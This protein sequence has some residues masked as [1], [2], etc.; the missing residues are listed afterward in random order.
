MNNINIYF[1][2]EGSTLREALS[3]IEDGKIK[4]ALVVNKNNSLIGTM[5]DGDV[6]RAI[7]SNVDLDQT[8]NN[9]YCTNP[10][11]ASINDTKKY[12]IDLCIVNQIHQIPVLDNN[13]RIVRL[14]V[15]DELLSKKK[16]DNKVILMV[17][18]LGERLRPFTD[19]TPKPMLSVG[20]RPILQTIVGQILSC[21]FSNIIMC[22]GYR[23]SI[24]Q[25]FFGDGSKFGVKIEYI[26][27][28]ERMGTIG[29]LSL[30]TDQQKPDK[31][32]IVMNGDLLTKARFD[33]LI[34]FHVTNEAEA[35]ISVKEH[36]FKVPY[37]VLNLKDGRVLSLEEKPVKNYFVSAGIYVLNPLLI[38]HINEKKYLDI[39][40]FFD[41]LIALN[42]TIM[43]FPISEYWLDIGGKAEF[44]KANNE[45]HKVFN[46]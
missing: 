27:E 18:G 9:H 2:K 45:Y 42:K 16:Y 23:S 46:V 25:D 36:N 17:G 30:L 4:V 43:A 8:I 24:I 40:E 41:K 15:L 14:D 7:L 5:S 44:D 19:N 22:V 10:L 1:L 12:I 32:F 34:D 11:V 26:I 21:G 28:D 31:P 3:V 35:T 37:G 39:T 13:N 38:S 6:R 33:S 20:N 29:A